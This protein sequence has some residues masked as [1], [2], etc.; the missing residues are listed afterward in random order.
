MYGFFI[1]VTLF[2]RGRPTQ[3]VGMGAVE[4]L[5]EGVWET[6]LGLCGL[7]HNKTIRHTLL[8]SPSH[9]SLGQ[10]N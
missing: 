9:A 6:L 10:Y 2:M 5:G 4:R 7:S 8:A 1:T 3:H